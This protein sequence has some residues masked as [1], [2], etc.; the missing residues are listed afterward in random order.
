[1]GILKD[2]LHALWL[3]KRPLNI[4]L[5]LAAL[6][7]FTFVFTFILFGPCEIYIQNKQEMPFPFSAMVWTLLLGGLLVFAVLFGFLLL[8]RGKIFNYAVSVLFAITVAGYLQ[9]NLLGLHSKTLDGNATNWLDNRF[10]MLI[11]LLLWFSILAAVFLLLY[12]SR[13]VW[14]RGIKLV[15]GILIGAQLVAFVVLL[16]QNGP[17]HLWKAG[18]GDAYVSREG[19]FEIAPKQNVIVFLLDRMDNQYMDS[20]LELHPEWRE[21]LGDFTYYHNFTGSYSNTRPAISYFLTGAQ[22]DYSVPWETYFK[23]AW[24]N[25]KYP[26]LPDIH[27]AGFQTNVYT[28]GTYVFGDSKDVEDFVDNI[29]SSQRTVHYDELFRRIMEMSIYRYAPEALQPFFQIYTGD[30]GNIV[31]VEGEVS[32][33]DIYI[34]DDVTFWRDYREQGLQ[35]DPEANGAFFYYHLNG[36]HTPYC[37]DENAEAISEGATLDAQVTGTMRMIFR[38]MDE[39]KEMGLYEDTT[40]IITTDHGRPPKIN[41]DIGDVSDSRVCTLMIKP[42]GVS[43]N[44]TMQVSNKEV[45]QDNLRASIISYFGLDAS[46]Y[47]RT[48]ESIGEDEPMTRYVW[49]RGEAGEVGNKLFTF[50]ITGDANDFSNWELIDELTMVY[51]GL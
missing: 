37:M 46:A 33:N 32:G 44:P 34:L 2:K 21:Q 25:P 9:G 10:S 7:A 30:L 6:G 27:D 16:A 48:I 13:K 1:M 43:G 31:T 29:R 40:I 42:A 26:F 49:I 28:E 47:G 51:T 50:K 8:L 17:H 36:A 15:C 11:S 38:Y 12:V 23:H 39:L 19:M 22:H 14:A 18:R 45:C 5:P 24:N 35:I 3:D 4:R 20:E 41:G